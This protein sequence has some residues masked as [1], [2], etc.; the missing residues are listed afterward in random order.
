MKASDYDLSLEALS[1]GAYSLD[2]E[3]AV[4]ARPQQSST[5][6]A[7]VDVAVSQARP[8]PLLVTEFKEL[9]AA[10]VERAR[11]DANTVFAFSTI[12]E[13]RCTGS[14]DDVLETFMP[15]RGAKN[16]EPGLYSVL[17]DVYG[18]AYYD[19]R[20]KSNADILDGVA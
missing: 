9:C 19:E 4:C 1:S 6:Q 15:R 11:R 17:R 16:C 20:L 14:V 12:L 18:R 7:P 2:S 3:P 13:I 5:F 10:V 8:R